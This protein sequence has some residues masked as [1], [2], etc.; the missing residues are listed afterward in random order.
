MRMQL[1]SQSLVFLRRA[2]VADMLSWLRTQ[3]NCMNASF[4]TTWLDFLMLSGLRGVMGEYSMPNECELQALPG[5]EPEKS[6]L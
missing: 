5:G 4:M 3:Q 6:V 2:K 1:A